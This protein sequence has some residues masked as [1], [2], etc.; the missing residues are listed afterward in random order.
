MVANAI[1]SGFVAT[2]RGDQEANFSCPW[3]DETVERLIKL[4]RLRIRGGWSIR[5]RSAGPEHRN[6]KISG[7]N[8]WI[9]SLPQTGP[10]EGQEA[11]A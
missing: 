9:G 3:T 10:A 4:L 2:Q 6:G 11:V 5:L 8:E 1:E 7:E